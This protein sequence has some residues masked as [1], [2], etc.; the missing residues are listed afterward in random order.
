M[1]DM[2]SNGLTCSGE[3]DGIIAQGFEAGGHRGTFT[4]GDGA[5]LIGTM[6]LVPQV[7]NVVRIPVIA[8]GGIAAAAF[9]L[10]AGGVQIGTAFLGCPEATVPDVHRDALHRAADED[11]RL[12]RVFTGRPARV[13]R[14]RLTDELGDEK[15]L[16]FP[17]QVSLTRPLIQANSIAFLPIWS[18]QGAP[19]IRDLP[20]ANLIDTLVMEARDRL[21][22]MQLK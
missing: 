4:A 15:A 5:N 10:G 2:T 20:A 16:E 18:G 12:T 8:A 14:N 6:A 22:G 1:T 19:L 3:C 17:A 21:P 11:T 9:A 13:L 7:V